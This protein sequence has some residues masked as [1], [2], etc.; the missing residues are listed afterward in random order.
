MRESCAAAPPFFRS[1][2]HSSVERPCYVRAD[3][4]GSEIRIHLERSGV[5]AW[6]V[7]TMG[8]RRRQALLG[9]EAREL[10]LHALADAVAVVLWE[11]VQHELL[12]V[13]LDV[14]AQPPI[15]D[16]VSGFSSLAYSV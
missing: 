14:H 8:Q 6:Y 3:R 2:R 7:S 12:D 15:S 5:Q 4:M 11:A 1:S 9:E 16:S 10:L 13:K